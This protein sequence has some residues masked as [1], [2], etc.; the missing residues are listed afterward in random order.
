MEG[1]PFN[2]SGLDLQDEYDAGYTGM[3]LMDCRAQIA[4]AGM[5]GRT[6]AAAVL[7]SR[8]DTVNDAMKRLL[9][10]ETAGYFQNKL[11]DAALT[12]VERMA[13]T[14]FYPMLAGPKAGPTEQQV[15]VTVEKHLTN[16]ARFAV[17]PAGEPPADHPVPPE[18]ARPLIQW[19]N[20]TTGAHVLCCQLACNF[21]MRRQQK[22]RYEGMAPGSLHTPPTAAAPGSSPGLVALYSYACGG[23][24]GNGTDMALGP[25][26]WKPHAGGP[27]ALVQDADGRSTP[28]LYAYGDRSKA[29]AS[30]A[31]LVELQQWYKGA[32]S[33]ASA[34]DHYVVA[35]QAGKADAAAGGYKKVEALGFVWPAP[36]TENAS[37]RYGL[38]SISKDDRAYID[39]NYWHGRTWSP[40]IQLV[41]W[42]LEQYSGKE[43]RGALAG[44]VLQSKALLLKEWR[45][46]GNASAPG[47]S[48]AGSGRYVYENFGADT[49]EG[50][51][52]SSES[53]PMYSWGAL[54][55]FIGLQY[56]GYYD[57]ANAT[58][59]GA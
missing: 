41:Y 18:E 23:E 36:G 17:W 10:N 40:M 5:L 6:D 58:A 54:A 57:A 30:A 29:G 53:Q 26:G 48:Y 24:G 31:D 1:V 28:S 14:H 25:M 2:Q 59:T 32:S 46:Y 55:G 44:L 8:F 13:P 33:A 42:G 4:L 50:Y 19:R 15:K 43:A 3:F 16:P 52:Y 37:S 38:P 39:Q 34:P 49:G 22:T 47:G 11:S 12:P 21:E 7:Q 20:K 56:H 45:G 51:G 35:S 27:C 9:W